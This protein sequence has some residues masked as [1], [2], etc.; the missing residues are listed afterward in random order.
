[1]AEW[2]VSLQVFRFSL[3]IIIPA[4]APGLVQWTLLYAS[5]QGTLSHPTAR[6]SMGANTWLIFSHIRLASETKSIVAFREKLHLALRP[7][8]RSP[9]FF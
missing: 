6:V 2:Q 1:M 5:Y 7:L 4:N 8:G 9:L 3:P